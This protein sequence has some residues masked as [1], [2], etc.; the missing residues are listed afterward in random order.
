MG[1][2]YSRQAGSVVD[3]VHCELATQ[4]IQLDARLTAPFCASPNVLHAFEN[5][6]QA[7]TLRD[8]HDDLELRD[9]CSVES[10]VTSTT[11]SRFTIV[12]WSSGSVR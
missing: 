4:D 11:T 7:L 2:Y 10:L 5:F 8:Q 1:I 6:D 3:R 9:T 12:F